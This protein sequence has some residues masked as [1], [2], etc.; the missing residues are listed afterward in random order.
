[1]S[2]DVHR[3]VAL[4]RRLVDQARARVVVPPQDNA[5]GFWFGG[6][7]MVS[8]GDGSVYL[9]GRYRNA[10]DSRLGVAAGTRGLELAVFRAD[11]PA[12]EFEKIVSF[13]KASLGLPGR[14]VLSIE[15]S[16][17][18]VAA[19]G[20]VELFVSAIAKS[21][22][23]PRPFAVTLTPIRAAAEA[24]TQHSGDLVQT[25]QRLLIGTIYANI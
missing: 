17:L 22:T 8:G 16:A 11:S 7:N 24:F 13:D 12:A 4:G 18:R 23:P 25:T 1:M 14:Q 19:D 9:V 21:D 6:G 20:A 5:S 3:L 2:L 10:G 15:G